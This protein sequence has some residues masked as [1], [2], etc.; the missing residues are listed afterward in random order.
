MQSESTSDRAVRRDRRQINC[1]RFFGWAL[2]LFAVG[3]GIALNAYAV[4]PPSGAAGAEAMAKQLR[5]QYPSTRIDSVK[6]AVVPGLFEVVMGKNVAYVEPSGRYFVFG[7]VW[8]MQQ[9]RDTTAD[10]LGGLDK[11]DVGSLPTASAMTWIRGSGR[12]VLHVLADPLCGYC[13][14]LE[15]TLSQLDDVT[16]HVYVLPILGQES[17]RIAD[18]VWCAPRRDQAWRDWMLQGTQPP[19]AAANCNTD[20]LAFIEQAARSMG[21]Q[22]TPTLFSGD[23]RKRA[24]ALPAADLTAWL[25]AVPAKAATNSPPTTPTS[26]SSA[27]PSSQSFATAKTAAAPTESTLAKVNP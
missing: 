21:V 7:H 12:R 18:G 13:R 19:A 1:F 16:V 5:E 15:R 25:D 17:R 3:L 9:R 24:G 10:R 6:P 27:T 26:A 4:D 22:A 8:D 14:Q 11:V 2:A 20:G 23:G